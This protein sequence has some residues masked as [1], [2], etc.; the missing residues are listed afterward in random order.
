MPSLLGVSTADGSQTLGRQSGPVAPRTGVVV[1]EASAEEQVR[2][3]ELV[4]RFGNH[5]VCH[6]RAW[7]ASLEACGCGAPL[8]L[9]FE[10]DGEVLGCLPG[11]IKRVGPFRLFGSPLPGWQTISMG[12]A[13]DPARLS[14]SE[15]LGAAIP[16]LERRHGVHHIELLGRDL[17]PETMRA[18]GFRGRPF[19]TQ[20]VPLFPGDEPRTLRGL[21]DSARRNIRRAAKLGLVARFEEG[22]A[23]VDE[24]YDQLREVFIRGGNVIPFSRRRVLECFRHLQAA[25]H[26]AAIS[27]S[28]PDGG[29]T[30]ATGMFTIEGRELILWMWAHRTEA[31][32]HRPTEFMTWTVIQR[33]MAAGCTSFDLMGLGDFK[34][35]FGG[36]AEAT[37]HRWARSRYRWMSGLRVAAERAYRWQQGMR[38]RLLRRGM[39]AEPEGPPSSSEPVEGTSPGS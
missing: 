33:A 21:K 38:G 28:L 3:D 5:R 39:A 34:S 15:I 29:R 31:R 14:T 30:I 24:H 13:F 27:V 11:L 10:R 1:R 7:I 37:E 8:F 6:T 23:F 36:A 35:K 32:W 2:W 25:G 16:F 18:F 19:P 4:G 12:P 20:R 9:V 26:L 17:D 22:E